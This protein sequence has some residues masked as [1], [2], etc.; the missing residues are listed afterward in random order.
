[1]AASKVETGTPNT[2]ASVAPIRA[3]MVSFYD[4]RGI[5]STCRIETYGLDADDGK[6]GIIV[7][8]EQNQ[9]V[10]ST[11]IPSRQLKEHIR[12]AIAG[13]GGRVDEQTFDENVPNLS[14]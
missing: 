12:R 2:V 8:H 11:R 1:M 13:I 5:K 14:L 6:L 7:T 4:S 3:Y 10:E 9:L